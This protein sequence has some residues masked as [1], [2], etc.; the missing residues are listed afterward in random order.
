MSPFKTAL[1]A[2]LLLSIC[3]VTAGAAPP[4]PTLADRPVMGFDQARQAFKSPGMA[5]A[6]FMFWFWD[7]PLD[8][9]KMAE[10]SRVMLSQGF[11]P[12]Y[13][14]ARRS[15]IGTPGLPD[16]QWLT[17]P[18]FT[19]FD[20]AL[21]EAKARDAYLGYCDEYWWPSLQAN[22]RLIKQHPELRA[23]SLAWQIIDVTAG[24]TL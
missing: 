24:S 8:P 18:W 16:D 3:T 23:Q 9:A 12:G 22:G 17:D 21:K 20:A 2:A 1:I 11:N 4:K 6:P 13:A 14:H 15:M 19:A 5:Y 10:M 7:E